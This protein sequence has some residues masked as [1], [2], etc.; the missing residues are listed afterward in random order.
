MAATT[1]S[2]ATWTDGSSGTVIDNAALGSDVYDKIDAL[3]TSAFTFGDLVHAEGFGL[4][5][6][7]SGGTGGAI[8]NLVNTTSGTGNYSALHLGENSDTDAG[9]LEAYS[10]AFTPSGA[11]TAA[12]VALRSIGAGGLYLAAENASGDVRL[13]ANGTSK[14]LTFAG[15][16]LEAAGGNRGAAHVAMLIDGSIQYADDGN[17]A[18][19]NYHQLYSHTIPA[20]VL[21]EDGRALEYAVVVDYATA[22]SKDLEVYLGGSGGTLIH[23]VLNR[24]DNAI[25][26]L[27][28]SITRTGSNAQRCVVH[29]GP[30]AGSIRTTLTDTTRTDSSSMELLVQ[31][32]SDASA[33]ND[34]VGKYGRGLILN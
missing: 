22:N 9:R 7:S 28:I 31:G 2:R 25:T 16:T 33:A 12:G 13:Y 24:T 20:N 17:G 23:Q 5:S 8:L 10:T 11:A 3:F 32:R 30:V 34:L 29:H 14:T 15:E 4:H 19:A 18:D 27:W 6:W 26:R 1:I 21:N